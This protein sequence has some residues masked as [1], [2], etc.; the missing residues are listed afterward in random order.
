[1][2]RGQ[3][4]YYFP[5]KE[6]ILLAVFDRLVLLMHQRIGEPAPTNGQ[7]ASGWEWVRH[8]LE[9]LVTEPPVSPEF[10][11]LQYTFLAQI[12]HRDDFR[13]RL[14]NLYESWRSSMALGL[15]ADMSRAGAPTQVA[16]RALASLVQAL[17]HGLIVQRAAD[18]RAFNDREMVDLCLD[19][20]GTYLRPRTRPLSKRRGTRKVTGRARRP[21]KQAV[22][23]E[24][25]GERAHQ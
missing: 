11:C 8:L 22:R 4:T 24:V 17:L 15:A 20:L 25:N 18:P 13:K 3:L 21:V 19:M 6:D 9:K 10:G 7:P 1:M 16:P 2:S 5:T 12:G 14:A 23:H